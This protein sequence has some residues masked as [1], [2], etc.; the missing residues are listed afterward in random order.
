MGNNQLHDGG[1]QESEGRHMQSTRRIG[2]GR[3]FSKFMMWI[4]DFYF[5]SRRKRAYFY[6]LAGVNIPNP[7]KVFIGRGVEFDNIS[8]ELIS[9]GN[10]VQITTGAKILTHF[11]D[12]TKPPFK[13]YSKPVVIKDNV[14]IGANAMIV[15]ECTIGNNVVIA[16]GSVVTKD[17]PDN[18][19][20]GGVPAKKIG[21]RTI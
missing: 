11:L 16:A 21:E 18:W 5:I 4:S 8:P 2:F 6:R 14:F 17:I 1:T 15:K 12:V 3:F 10:N 20:V 9:I 7:E 19:I 13:F